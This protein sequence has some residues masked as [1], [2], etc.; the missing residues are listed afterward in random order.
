[1]SRVKSGYFGQQINSD[2]RLQT[3][4]IQMKRLVK[5]RLI[6]IFAFCLVNLIVIPMIQKYKKQGR[7]PN[8]ANCPD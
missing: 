7:C 6:R 4:K 3:V 8:L 1:M 5:S 2:I